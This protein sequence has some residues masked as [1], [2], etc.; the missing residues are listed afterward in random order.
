MKTYGKKRFFKIVKKNDGGYGSSSKLFIPPGTDIYV[1]WVHVQH[2]KLHNSITSIGS[3]AFAYSSNLN[4]V[5]LPNGLTSIQGA[6]FYMC[7]NLT[8]ITLPSSLTSIGISA[9]EGAGLTSISIPSGVTSIGDS[10]F[11]TCTSLASISLPEGL[12]SIGYGA[13]GVCSAL[14]S[15][16]LPRS[17][18]SLGAGAFFDCTSITSFTSLAATASSLS[19]NVFHGGWPSSCTLYYPAGATGYSSGD[20]ALFTTTSILST[21]EFHSNTLAIYPNPASSFFT[22]K[23]LA[24]RSTV[25]VLDASGKLVLSQEVNNGSTINVEGL[26]KGLYLVKVGT[27]V[28]KLLKR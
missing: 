27:Q 21:T 7:T 18:T 17:L 26:K 2:N 9:F 3:Q 16:T 15:V 5:S 10:A 4:S 8:S 20:W 6:V 23:G 19:P 22:L 25:Q 24:K 1:C 13:F 28:L 11:F 14:T 12:T